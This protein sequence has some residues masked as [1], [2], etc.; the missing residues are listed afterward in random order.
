[1]AKINLVM[2]D[3]RCNKLRDC[4]RYQTDQLGPG[5]R[6]SP[7]DYREVTKSDSQKI[8]DLR[9]VYVSPLARLKLSYKNFQDSY[10]ITLSVVGTVHK[11]DFSKSTM[12]GLS[13]TRAKFIDVSFEKSN[14]FAARLP[15]VV[16]ENVNLKKTNLMYADLGFSTFINVDL[17]GADLSHANLLG[18]IFKKVNLDSETK[19]PIGYKIKDLVK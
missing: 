11:T 13:A 7:G 10:W 8:M 18:A 3:E 6:F 12:K 9:G 16:F 14:L 2:A 19:L 1:M 15:M 17:R 5:Y 4:K